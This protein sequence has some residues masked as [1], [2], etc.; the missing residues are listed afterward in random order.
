VTAPTRPSR[1]AAASSLLRFRIPAHRGVASVALLLVVWMVAAGSPRTTSSRRSL[2]RRHGRDP[3]QFEL[4]THALHD[5][6]GASRLGLV[7][8]FLIGTALGLA[9]G[10]LPRFGRVLM[11]WLQISQGIP[12]LSWVVIA[13]IWFQAVELRIASS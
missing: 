11:P 8:S 1:G 3:D 9:H 6:P 13:I 4:L 10:L 7:A 12:S 2:G 5:H